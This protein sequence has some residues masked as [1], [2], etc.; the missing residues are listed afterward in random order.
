MAWTAPRTWTDGE[1]VTAAIMNPHIRD[2]QLAEGPHLIVR[3]TSDQSVTS[4][5]VLVDDTALVLPL[6]ANEV[7]QYKFFVVYGAGTTGDIKLGWT[8]PTA[9]D[10]RMSGPAANDSGGTLTYNIFSTTTSPTTARNY[11][12]AGT[13]AYTSLPFEGVFVNGANAG[14]L[15][16]QFAQNTSDATST[17]VKAN[18]TLWA[19]KLA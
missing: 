1:L 14:N 16:F 2:N 4:S 5:T 9:G 8:F 12:G 17:T 7:W 10:L 15:T 6:L 3:K 13:A 11:A 19:V 18:S